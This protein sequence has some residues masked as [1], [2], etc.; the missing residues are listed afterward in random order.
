LLRDLRSN[1]TSFF[2]FTEPPAPTQRMAFDSKT[3]ALII[4]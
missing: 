3:I 2:R 4:V 1:P